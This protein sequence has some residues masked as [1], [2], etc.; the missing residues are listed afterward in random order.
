MNRRL[1]AAALAVLCLV[2]VGICVLPN[3]LEKQPAYQAYS[4]PLKVN[5]VWYQNESP[6]R[7]EDG[8]IYL[9]LDALSG[10][11]GI[12]SPARDGRSA[13]FI[14]QTITEGEG[15]VISH[16]GVL[17]ASTDTLSSLGLNVYLNLDSVSYVDN[18]TSFDYTW[19][20]NNR[21]VAH[22]MGGYDG[23]AYT[24]S[25]EAFL[26]N[27]ELGHRVF[28]VDFAISADDVLIAAHQWPDVYLMQYRDPVIVEEKE[29]YPPLT[30][31]EFTGEY[32]Y[33][34]Q[35][36]LTIDNVIE[37]MIEYPDIYVVTDTKENMDGDLMYV[38]EEIIAAAEYYDPSVLDRIIP[39]LY[40]FDMYDPLFELYDWKS[41]I[42]TL[43]RIGDFH[44]SRVF[45][46]AYRHGIKAIT[47]PAGRSPA[48]FSQQ[49]LETGGYL[50]LHTYN[51]LAMLDPLA[52]TRSIY[53]V[54]TDYL[55]P[56]T[57][58]DLPVPISIPQ[59][60]LDAEAEQLA[61]IE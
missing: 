17:Y 12:A 48:E 39:Q 2:L 33:E 35:T 46:F 41:L 34:K 53:G 22:A 9:P 27:Y 6:V 42:L 14:G 7:R 24:N 1:I 29:T 15:G 60:L 56:D 54:Y 44:P 19:A 4:F 58:D 52:K 61:N 50:Y 57:F 8:S 11:L 28:E 51:T 26:Y 16:N 47:A 32:F 3:L 31:E 43:Y 30:V 13:S 25:L 36:P 59:E 49:I 45:D 23:Y 10:M 40:T 38:F 5:N 37:L 21:V 18:F 20:D 55:T